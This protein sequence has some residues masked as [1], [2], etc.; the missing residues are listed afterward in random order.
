MAD[1]DSQSP[2]EVSQEEQAPV[3]PPAG[4]S[5]HGL[6]HCAPSPDTEL[7]AGGQGVQDGKEEEDGGAEE[8]CSVPPQRY[9]KH[10][11]P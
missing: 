10:T 5:Q 6:N 4:S 9:R 3:V 1:S 7:H 2:P 11:D 8:A